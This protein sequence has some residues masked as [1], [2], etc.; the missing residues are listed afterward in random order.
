MILERKLPKL[1]RLA[2]LLALATLV[3][4]GH[5]DTAQGQ[6]LTFSPSPVV[7][8]IPGPGATASQVVTVAGGVPINS[9]FVS[10]IDTTPPLNW[11]TAT[12]ANGNTFTLNAANTSTLTPGGTYNG[13]V[14]VVANGSGGPSGVLNVSL[15]IGSNAG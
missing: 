12:G 15:T 13:T 10:R 7:L 8:N 1:N 3:L 11:L 2:E 14:T 5:P 9:V 6:S 4:L